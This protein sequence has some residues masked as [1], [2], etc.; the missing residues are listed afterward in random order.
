MQAIHSLA[1]DLH[2]ANDLWNT[3]ELKID[4]ALT[5]DSAIAGLNSRE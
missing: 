1:M 3:F 2:Y 5:F 4:F